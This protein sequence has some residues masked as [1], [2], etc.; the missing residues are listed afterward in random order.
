MYVH[1]LAHLRATVCASVCMRV[2][3]CVAAC[4]HGCEWLR[5]LIASSPG[6][7]QALHLPSGFPSCTLN[8]GYGCSKFPWSAPG[9]GNARD[10]EW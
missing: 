5:G 8:L 6:Y 2:C 9:Y 3:I 7:C 4:G 10:G 1:A